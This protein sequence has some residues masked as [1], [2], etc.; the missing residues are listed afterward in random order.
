MERAAPAVADSGAQS[1]G[2]TDFISFDA[3]LN[4]SANPIVP[5][6][7]SGAFVTIVANPDLAKISPCS[8]D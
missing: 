1:L 7:I 3:P 6:P 5:G 2:A 8:N 4:I